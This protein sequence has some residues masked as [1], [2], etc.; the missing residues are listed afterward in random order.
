M[1]ASEKLKGAKGEREFSKLSREDW[2]IPARRGR[3]YSGGDDSP[4]VIVDIH[5]VHFEV[6]RTN[7]LR[8]YA[9]LDQATADAPEGAIPVVAHR[10]D[11]RKWVICLYAT[12]VPRFATKFI[13]AYEG[14]RENTRPS[15]M[16]DYEY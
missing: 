5:S 4:D 15:D 6:K 1:G 16:S 12:D 2:G 10:A 7:R 3:Q 11:K 8:L 14:A 9:A 13:D